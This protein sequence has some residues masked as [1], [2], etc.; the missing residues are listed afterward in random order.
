M[1]EKRID[2][3]TETHVEE[4][5]EGATTSRIT[6][7]LEE[8]V[9]MEVRKVIKETIVPVITNRRIEEYENGVMV[10]SET[11]IVPEK[12]TS[13]H[14]PV[15][16]KEDIRQAVQ[17]VLKGCNK[18]CSTRSLVEERVN[19]GWHL[20]MAYVLYAV[21]ALEAAAIVYFVLLKGIL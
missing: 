8:K 4:K 20:N 12:A 17:E 16:S 5:T 21:L 19:G 2:R 1:E 11:E 3:R 10:N 7:F 18:K 13:L 15:L 9:P 6:T 14:Q